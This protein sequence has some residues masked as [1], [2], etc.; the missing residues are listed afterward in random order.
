MTLA[1]GSQKVDHVPIVWK[2]SSPLALPSVHMFSRGS[3]H[4]QK[5]ALVPNSPLLLFFSTAGGFVFH[6]CTVRPCTQRPLVLGGSQSSSSC[7]T[8]KYWQAVL[9]PLFSL[10]CYCRFV[11]N[12]RRLVTFGFDFFC[13]FLVNVNNFVFRL[14]KRDCMEAWTPGSLYSH[15][16]IRAVSCFKETMGR[17]GV[18]FMSLILFWLIQQ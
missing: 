9:L 2:R 14:F 17:G 18:S 7:S 16:D 11:C 10:L 3:H 13:R 15:T 4:C 12:V 1:Y 6:Y 5:P 8:L